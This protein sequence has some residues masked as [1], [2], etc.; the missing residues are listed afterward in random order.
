[1]LEQDLAHL[2]DEV[3]EQLAILELELSEGD[4]TQKGY[5]K[6]RN[7]ILAKFTKGCNAGPGQSKGSP[8]TRAHRQHQRRLTRDETRFHSEI[9]AEAV[10]QALA[11]YSQGYKERPSIV[12]PIKRP[13]ESR[14]RYSRASDSSSDDDDSLVGSLKRK[15]QPTG[16]HNAGL[17]GSRNGNSAPPDVTGGAAVE[18][19]LRRVREQHEIKLQ[20]QR[21]TE[22]R[23]KVSSPKAADDAKIE[24]RP[25][26]RIEQTTK[27]DDDVE[28]ATRLI[29]EVVYVNQ[30]CIKSSD[31]RTTPPNANNYQNAIFL[32]K[33]LPK[34][35]QKLQQ[36]VNCL[37]RQR[38]ATSQV[39]DKFLSRQL[40]DKKRRKQVVNRLWVE[41]VSHAVRK[42]V[43]EVLSE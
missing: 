7:L 24:V 9:R 32:Q 25:C 15:T 33:K 10:Q 5:E 18:A 20:I 14:G 37:Q 11:E 26:K 40:V 27:I 42:L 35:S 8:G 41:K 4:I 28:Q 6:K 39:V 1:M 43:L 34:L 36:V 19:M 16:K 13:T 31:G 29:D 2:P 22:S 38:L 3:R 23:P 17:G 30:D 12:Q 21:E